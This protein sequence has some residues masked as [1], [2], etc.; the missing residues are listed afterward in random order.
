MLAAVASTVLGARLIIVSAFG[1]SMPV[2]DQWD[3]EGQAL[4][5]P[6]LKGNLSFVDLFASHNGHR[7][8]LTRL[9]A[10]AHLELAG[11]WN[12]RLEMIF[13]AVVLTAAVTFLAALLIPFIPPHR[14]LL[15]SCFVA[16][17]FAFPIDFENTLWGFQ[18][19]MHLS[20]LLGLTALVA[21]AA[22]VPFSVR[23]FC[24]LAAAV[25]GF[26][27]FATSLANLPAAGL[28]VG[29]QM[30]M[31]ARRRSS[32]EVAALGIMAAIAIAM[33][34]WGAQGAKTMASASTFLQGLCIYAFLTIGAVIPLF[35]YFRRSLAKCSAV[36]DR[37]WIL[38]AL[39]GWVAMQLVLIAYGR[40]NIVAPRY[41]DIVLLLYP[42]AFV[43]VS[44]LFDQ[45]ANREVSQRLVLGPVS[46][47]F[48]VAAVFVLAGC[49]SV[50]A[51]SY[52]SRAAH[53][54][55]ADVRAYLATKDLER[56]REKGSPSHGVTLTHPFPERQA[57]VL[58]D[59]E[60]RAILP[61][62]VRPIGAQGAAAWRRLWLNGR[63]AGA[64]K[65]FVHVSLAVGPAVLS[66]G[67]ALFFSAGM[68]QSF[69][70][71]VGDYGDGRS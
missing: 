24:G 39:S 64:T 49:V 55:E 31:G 5:S 59:P 38:F 15:L 46:W 66:V 40:G 8:L 71:R 10:L 36:A 12:T 43:A 1:S 45:R 50:L 34:V 42:M 6:Y 63:L 11:E 16:L 58:D 26:F 48:A 20:L 60:M 65:A 22:A 18:S 62:D 29:L 47:V 14:Q 19:Q 4:Y 54:Q 28:V 27:A 17:G 69:K 7:I 3:A 41:L 33:A 52:W 9:V 25:L 51:C 61:S 70:A 2:L 30:A 21:F 23:W 44:A 35:A 32:R 68:A 56:L 53:Q 37:E 57:S 67:V 13:S